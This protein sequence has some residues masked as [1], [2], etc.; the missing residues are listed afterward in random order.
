MMALGD[1]FKHKKFQI[2]VTTPCIL[3]IK[4]ATVLKYFFYI[5][6]ESNDVS[7]LINLSMVALGETFKHGKSQLKV[8]VHAF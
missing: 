1:S 5:L 4:L 3:S 2:K 6:S 7:R 8:T